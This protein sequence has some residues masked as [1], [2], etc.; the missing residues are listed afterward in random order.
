M[1]RKLF[2]KF[3][4]AFTGVKKEVVHEQSVTTDTYEGTPGGKH[5]RAKHSVGRVL[6]KNNRYGR[7]ALNPLS[8]PRRFRHVQ[9]K[10][11]PQV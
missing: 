2:N 10:V 5:C 11:R 3:K 4:A 8:N 1:I 9:P 6:D 7:V